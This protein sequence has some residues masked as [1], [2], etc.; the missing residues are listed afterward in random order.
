MVGINFAS[1][2]GKK[3][4]GGISHYIIL[5]NIIKEMGFLMVKQFFFSWI[6][7]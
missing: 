7:S 2:Q 3:F 5:C 1:L 6:F 4:N